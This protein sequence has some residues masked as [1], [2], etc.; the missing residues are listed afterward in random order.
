MRY[1]LGLVL[2]AL[3]MSGLCVVLEVHNA[4]PALALIGLFGANAA[5]A[6]DG[7]GAVL[8]A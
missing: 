8:P 3:L 6:D 1:Y 2:F 5:D 7:V 4:P